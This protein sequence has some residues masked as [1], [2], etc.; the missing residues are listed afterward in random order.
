MIYQLK[1]SL[2]K[3]RNQTSRYVKVFPKFYCKSE[4]TTLEALSWI[5]TRLVF[6]HS[7]WYIPFYMQ[8]LKTSLNNLQMEV[9]HIFIMGKMILSWPWALVGSSF[10]IILSMSSS[11]SLTED[12]INFISKDFHICFSIWLCHWRRLL[13]LLTIA[14]S[15]ANYLCWFSLDLCQVLTS[16]FLW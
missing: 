2:C 1:L 9:L 14:V 5:G 10:A 13:Y 11:V 12:N 8:W 16:V 4:V 3:E 7:H 15:Y 6:F